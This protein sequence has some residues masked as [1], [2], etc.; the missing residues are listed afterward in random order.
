MA[1]TVNIRL[2]EDKTDVG[3][4]IATWNAGDADEFVY[5]ARAKA[6][7]GGAANYKAAAIAARDADIAKKALEASLNTSMEAFMNG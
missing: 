3:H 6:G 5:S 1:W 7:G 4:V 2:D